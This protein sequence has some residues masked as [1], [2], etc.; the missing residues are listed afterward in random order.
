MHSARK[1]QPLSGPQDSAPSFHR[2]ERST[3][4]PRQRTQERLRI[5]MLRMG[6]KCFCRRHFDNF[7]RI[8]QCNA[9]SDPRQQRKVMSDENK[10]QTAFVLQVIEELENLTR[11]SDIQSRGRSSATMM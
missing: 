3:V 6:K 4:R 10:R 9:I 1:A 8:H 5:R 11:Y 7:T 2:L